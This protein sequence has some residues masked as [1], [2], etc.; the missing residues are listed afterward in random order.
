MRKWFIAVILASV[1][2][3]PASEPSARYQQELQRTAALREERH[4]A[5]ATYQ[6]RQ[7]KIARDSTIAAGL[8]YGCPVCGRQH[9]GASHRNARQ[10]A[11]PWVPY[12]RR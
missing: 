11:R 4:R 5:L 3:S 6:Q 2:S 8:A 7:L 9:G 12:M 1:S 10:Y